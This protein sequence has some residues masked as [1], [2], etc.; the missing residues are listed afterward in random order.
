MTKMRLGLVLTF[1]TLLAFTSCNRDFQKISKSTDM[2]AKFDR[3]KEY[4]NEGDCFKAIPLFEEIITYYKGSRELEEIYYSYAYCHFAQEDFIVAAYHFN[5]F[6]QLYPRSEKVV[7]AAFM[8]AQCNHKQSP[9]FSLDQTPTYEAINQYQRFVERYPNSEK[10]KEAN[11]AIDELRAKLQKKAIAGAKLYFKIKDYQ[12]A[13]TTFKNLIEEF[14][15]SKDIEES[16]YYVVLS[17]KLL[18]DN[19]YDAKKKERYEETIKSFNIFKQKF[20]TSKF[21]PELDKINQQSLQYVNQENIIITDE[22]KKQRG[23]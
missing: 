19:S 10:V 1:S 4:Y 15:E 14:P 7:D 13:A 6:T 18:A 12:A 5:R 3:A 11:V 2:D 16:Y 9:K 23:S 17:N 21:L 20:P 8:V 22:P